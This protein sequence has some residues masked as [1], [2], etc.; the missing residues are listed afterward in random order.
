MARLSQTELIQKTKTLTTNGLLPEAQA[1]ISGVGYNP[2]ALAVG[3]GYAE[4]VFNGPSEV[5]IAKAA[6]TSATRA[7]E[8]YRAAA[9]REATAFAETA[10]IIFADDPDTLLALDLQTHYE[11]VT[12]AETGDTKKVA[13]RASKATADVIV[14]WTTMF[15]NGGTLPD[16]PK[17]L[18]TSAGWDAN[19]LTAALDAVEAYANADIAQQ[20]AIGH[21]QARSE[22]QKAD[23]ETLRTW[24]AKA[25]NLCR[26]AIKRANPTNSQQLLE[27]LGLV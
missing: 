20:L 14:H 6:Q 13:T 26:I 12:D 17:A 25:S 27:I 21:Y 11:T 7:E 24:Y 19:R 3:A 5:K 16:A 15:T 10:R 18:L 4:A 2:A 9:Q 8:T 22:Q 1:L 23:V